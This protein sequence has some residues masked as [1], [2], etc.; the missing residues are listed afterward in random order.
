MIDEREIV[1]RAVE[2]LDPPEPAFERLRRRRDRKRRTQRITAGVVGIAVFVAAIWIVTSVGSFDRTQT[3]AVPGGTET[4]PAVTGP[5]TPDETNVDDEGFP[6]AG[7]VPSTPEEGKIIGKFG[8]YKAG[9]GW[10]Y[11]DGRV[12]WTDRYGVVLNE[13][14]LS[15]EGVQLLRTGA[16]D[17]QDLLGA[18]YPQSFVDLTHVPK[19]AWEDL[20]TREY[21]PSRYAICYAADEYR[22]V[23]PSSVEGLLPARAEALLRGKERI[24]KHVTLDP[25][26]RDSV[27][28]APCFEVTTEDA[29][30]LG[31][32]LRDAGFGRSY[33]QE[34]PV[35]GFSFSSPDGAAKAIS[36]FFAPLLP[37]D[38]W[39]ELCRCA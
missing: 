32:I 1:R 27:P 26:V 6:P 24:Y 25:G 21:V 22:I 23:D 12:I 8:A 9:I 3:P 4:G 38:A 39:G 2:A 36:I 35:A 31:E 10:V 30:S 5:T 19:S 20:E 13:R 7:A 11:A 17:A 15:A 14:R 18:L 37:H 28:T 33:A 29:R 16:L 34:G